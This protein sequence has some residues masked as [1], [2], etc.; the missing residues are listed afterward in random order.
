MNLT[1]QRPSPAEREPSVASVVEAHR[2][3][4]HTFTASG[5]KSFLREQGSGPSVL[6]MH[7][8]WG[9]SF[10]YR[11]VIS[12][13]ASRGMRGIAFDLPGFGLAERPSDYDYSWTGLGRFALA[14]V[15]ALQLDRVHLV[16]HDIGGP[17][18]FELAA[19]IRGRVDSLTIFN[20]MIDVT[21]FNPPWSM[22][23]FRYRG[24]GEL[25]LKGLNRPMFRFLMRLQGIEDRDAIT[26]SE[27]DA[28]LA[29]MKEGD[30]G[31]SFLKVMRST[32]RTP[33]KQALYRSTVRDVPYPVQVV[34][35]KNDP[36]LSAA[37]Y[38][39]QARAATGLERIQLIPGKHF[40]QED[41]PA[42][43]AEHIARIAA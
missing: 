43:M 38:G 32:E 37:S 40:P 2:R 39:E 35:A 28:Y 19:K 36:A 34:W 30:H 25:W 1:A 42:A 33:E 20:T 7:G 21:G 17:V 31:R 10:L 26:N 27:L 3:A 18:G 13:L 23:P 4:G 6:C 29:L 8:M 11:K 22:Q 16:V 15:E 9:S 41:Q 5:I 14:A 24:L 12:E